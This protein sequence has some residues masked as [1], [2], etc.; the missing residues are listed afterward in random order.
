ML[1]GGDNRFSEGRE[2]LQ[3]RKRK[4]LSKIVWG[5]PVESL[6]SSITVHPM[7]A[8]VVEGAA[9]AEIRNS[10][11]TVEGETLGKDLRHLCVFAILISS[12]VKQGGQC[13]LPAGGCEI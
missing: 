6:G 12:C 7:L 8:Q 2:L 11:L 1:G 13:L 10:L 9:L 3:N 5:T 4:G